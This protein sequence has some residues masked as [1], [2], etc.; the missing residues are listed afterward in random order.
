MTWG[1]PRRALPVTHP[2][3]TVFLLGFEVQCG[4]ACKH[5]ASPL[6]AVT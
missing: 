1:T 3:E 4:H 5:S 2:P 6:V